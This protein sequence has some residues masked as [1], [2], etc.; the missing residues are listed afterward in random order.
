MTLHITNQVNAT[1]NSLIEG[2]N[3]NIV[4]VLVDHNTRQLVLPLMPCLSNAHVIEIAPGDE[5]KNL[6]ALTNVWLQMEQCGATRHSLLVN[7]GGGS[8]TD[9]GGFAAATFKR[10]INFINVP[11]TLLGAIDAAVGGK[12]AINFNGLKNEIGAFAP[13]T[14]V[15]VSSLFF[16]T[17]PEQEFKSGFAEMVKHA[18]LHSHEE[19]EQLLDFDFQ[20]INYDLL[21]KLMQKS[22]QVKQN[23]VEQDPTEQ[24]LRKTLNLGHTVG[25]AFES[26]ALDDGKPVPHGYA[27]A[28]GLVTEAVLSHMRLNFPSNDLYSLARFVKQNY[29]APAINCDHYNQL[30]S[31]MHHDKKSIGG[32][33]NCTLLIQ[34]G[35]P[36]IDNSI[37]DDTMKSALDILRDLLGI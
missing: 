29:G 11:T 4:M 19:F 12:T 25:H 28:W 36:K 14:A 6:D 26:K 24:G 32:E 10:G 16:G 1:L 5:N 37:D 33:I 2:G 15:I 18:M 34:C 8:V 13:A 17:L 7:L 20:D 22:L 27:V 30:L 35:E 3:Y 23:I 21:L 31:L 9:L